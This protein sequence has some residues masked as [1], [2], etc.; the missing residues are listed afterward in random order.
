ME[1]AASVSTVHFELKFRDWVW[2]II[3]SVPFLFTHFATP[4]KLHWTLLALFVVYPTLMTVLAV[5]QRYDQIHS[6][7]LCTRLTVNTNG[8]A[9]QRPFRKSQFVAFSDLHR[10]VASSTLDAEFGESTTSFIL[11]SAQGK[12]AIPDDLFWQSDL[13]AR[14]QCLPNFDWGAYGQIHAPEGSLWHCFFPRRT[15]LLRKV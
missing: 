10:V 1:K 3:I 8:F 2:S 7:R 9:L 11:Y 13:L 12:L 14:L 15:E 5:L 6:G 4:I